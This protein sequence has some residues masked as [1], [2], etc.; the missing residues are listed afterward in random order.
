MNVKNL[1]QPRCKLNTDTAV[2]P[3]KL[4]IISI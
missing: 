2:Y 1:K 4:Q 3:L